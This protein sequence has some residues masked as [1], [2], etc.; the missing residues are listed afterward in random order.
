MSCFNH[1]DVEKW[2][3]EKNGGKPEKDITDDLLF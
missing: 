1:K 2:I 3:L